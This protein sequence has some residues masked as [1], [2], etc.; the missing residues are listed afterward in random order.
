MLHGSFIPDIG[1]LNG[2]TG[3]ALFFYEYSRF[4][5]EKVYDEF[6]GELIDEICREINKDTALDFKEGLCGIGWGIEYLIRNNFV[7]ADPDE[8]FEEFDRRIV[9]WNVRQIT[10]FSLEKG[11]CGIACYVVARFQNRLSVNSFLT[12]DYCN[13]LIHALEKNRA[14]D[15]KALELKEILVRIMKGEN[16]KT[17]YNPLS[18]II[19]KT[20][21]NAAT[22][23]EKQ[24]PTG[25]IN[26]GYAGIGLKLMKKTKS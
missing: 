22:L 6:A 5:G 17:F 10:D 26:N 4:A 20:K 2:K 12:N 13:D 1:L 3:I 14:N 19:D 16:I 23:F 18:N 11:L 25:I 9:E 8:V 7:K 21:Y 15:E 24:L